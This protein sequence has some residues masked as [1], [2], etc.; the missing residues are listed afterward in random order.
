[1]ADEAKKPRAVT[2]NALARNHAPIMV[3]TTRGTDSVVTGLLGQAT[4]LLGG[5]P[6]ALPVGKCSL[7]DAAD[8]RTGGAGETVTVSL[9]SDDFDAYLFIALARTGEKVVT[10]DDGG[11]GTDSEV[12]FTL[13]ESGEYLIRATSLMP[14]EEGAYVLTLDGR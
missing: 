8:S 12:T 9:R 1:M 11:S 2:P 3:L 6:G 13:P 5:T 4:G 14:N 7:T 10:D